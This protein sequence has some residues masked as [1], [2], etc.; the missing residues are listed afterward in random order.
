MGHSMG[1]ALTGNPLL[2]RNPLMGPA[3][4]ANPPFLPLTDSAIEPY[5]LEPAE[6]ITIHRGWMKCADAAQSD[7]IG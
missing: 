7:H 2:T 3:Q 5:C 1:P 6:S 4:I